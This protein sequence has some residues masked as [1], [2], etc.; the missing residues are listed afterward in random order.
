MSEIG[1]ARE[2]TLALTE[3]A[4]AELAETK[5]LFV[6]DRIDLLF[7][8]AASSRTASWPT[9]WPTACPPTAWS[10][11]AAWCRAGR[12]W[13]WPTI[14]ASRPARGRPDGGEDRPDDEVALARRAADLLVHR[15]A[16]PGSPTRSTVPGPRGPGGSSRNQVA[17]SGGCRDLLPVRPS[18]A[19]G[20]HPV[21]LRPGDHGRGR[22]LDVPRLAANGRD[23]GGGAGQPR[24]DGRDRM[25]AEVSGC[26]DQRPPT[27]PT[28]SSRRSST[29]PTCCRTA[30]VPA[31]LRGRR[32][33]PGLQPGVVPAADAAGYDIHTVIDALLDKGSFFEVKPLFAPELVV[34]LGLLDG[35]VVGV[36]ATSP[37]SR[38]GCVRRLGGQGR[39]VHLAVRRVQHP[40]ALPGRRAGHDRQRRGAAGIIRH[41]A[42][43]ITAV[44]EA[45]VP[46]VRSSSQGVP[47]RA[48]RHGRAG[49]RARRLPGAAT[50]KIA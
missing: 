34:G 28:R 7:D 20:V 50:A 46:T 21:V 5:K 32:G 30:G 35:E 13:W 8:A 14:P 47:G 39:P 25:H 41:G 18:A 26:G 37:R 24:G 27:T 15:L 22:R 19:G 11:A 23:G 16:V 40:A 12:P 43:M 4:A 9:P 3:R 33:R 2:R 48:V 6:R 36:V 29:S 45:T 31:H 49:L 42:K 1:A 10:P 38:A 17:L 44:A